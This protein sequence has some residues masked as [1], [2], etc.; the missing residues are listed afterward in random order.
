MLLWS[1]FSQVLLPILVLTGCGWVLDRAFRLDLG[2]L[3][4]LNFYLFVPCFLFHE[5]VTSS[6]QAGLAVRVM[7]FTGCIFAGMFLLSALVA[8]GM[9]YDRS[10]ERALQLATMFYNS[11]N[12]GVPL[13]AL[14]FPGTGPVLQVFVLLAQNIGTFTVGLLLASSGEERG[15]RRWVPMLKQASPWAVAFALLVRASGL[16]VMEWRWFWVPVEYLHKALVGVALVTLGVQLSRTRVRQSARRLSWA[17]GLRLFGGPVLAAFLCG[18]F[19]FRGEEAVVMIVSAA[20]P[21][22]V[23]TALLAHEFKADSDFAAAVVFY[24]TLASMFTVT[25]LIAVLRVPEVVAVF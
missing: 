22:A 8:R 1:V 20:F 11:G 25:C 9:G 21:T 13:M 19:G 3:V 10:Q 14:A 5:V 24:S 7:A 4:K 12:Y 2:T 6:L 16:P 23:N 17:L 15:W 18:A